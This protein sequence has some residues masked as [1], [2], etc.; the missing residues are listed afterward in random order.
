MFKSTS[1]V[2]DGIPSENYGVMIYFLD[3]KETRE[4]SIGTD[5]DVVEDRLPK[6]ISPIHYGADMNKSMSFP[7]T[8][9]STEYLSDYDVDAI[10]SWLTGHDQYKWL[11]YVEEDHYVRYKCHLN[12]MKSTYINGLPVAF[13][14]D[15][16]CDGQFAY[17]YNNRYEFDVS[18]AELSVDFINRSSYNGYLYPSM[19]IKFDDNCNGLS[20][21]NET[22][23]SREFKIDYFERETVDASIGDEII[24]TNFITI[25]SEEGDDEQD[26]I[27]W[28]SVSVS[29]SNKYGEIIYG[30]TT[31]VMLPTGGDIALYSGD[32]GENWEERPLPC[33]GSW[34][35]CYGNNGFVAVCTDENTSIAI[36]SLTGYEWC[37][38]EIELP[39]A[40]NWN[41]VSFVETSGFLGIGYYIAV[42]GASSDV[43]VYSST[44]LS[45][46][47]AE[48]PVAQN[49]TS[50]F[51]GDGK[52]IAIA[53][54]SN[55]AAI[56]SDCKFWEKVEL[57]RTAD[58]TDGCYGK[59]GFI[60]IC[61]SLYGSANR[62]GIALISQNGK[63]DWTVVDMPIGAW[64]NIESGSI[65]YVAIG[66]KLYASSVDLKSWETG[67]LPLSATNLSAGNGGFFSA[68]GTNIYLTTSF[69]ENIQGTFTHSFL[70]VENK[71]VKISNISIYGTL[72]NS[73]NNSFK[74]SGEKL[75]ASVS[76]TEFIG[77]ELIGLATESYGNAD[78]DCAMLSAEYDE[79]TGEIYFN[80]TVNKNNA[81]LMN[82]ELIIR[83]EYQKEELTDL[84]YNSLVANF[85]NQ[86]QII[87]T[88]K[89]SL[90]L[91]S[92][93]NMKFFRLVKGLNKLTF[94]TSGGNCKVILNCEFLRK[95]G[96]R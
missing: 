26:F 8:F 34:T 33:L 47:Q 32:G 7:L 68:T 48:L 10:L 31:C 19:E 71:D 89:D 80:Y 57:P 81:D 36:N 70:A 58:W 93:F 87:T 86:N 42:G 65:G 52:I 84:G 29:D 18:D 1:F 25:N 13:Q 92:Y 24:N 35:G 39:V 51:G 78:V 4:L 69:A 85:D 3:D 14:C 66:D 82:A 76:E 23:N 90:N 79:S 30:E 62:E 95:V 53:E 9:G 43:V 11:E 59:E 72:K 54:N 45:W 63:D 50:V 6:R 77:G 5:V 22:D 75:L 74:S 15:V 46:R 88:N 20:I 44:G 2:F 67:V 91:Y 28:K 64:S 94:A 55:V 40:Q 73:E 49:W 27:A 16:E 21:I 60:L 83:I 17:E 56:S 37:S 38:V 96:G 41:K 61:N 12:N